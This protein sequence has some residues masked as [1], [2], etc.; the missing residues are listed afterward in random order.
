M[1][2]RQQLGEQAANRI[3]V[4]PPDY[5]PHELKWVIQQMSWFCGTRMHSTIAGLSSG[6]PTIALS[7]SIKT[8]GVFQTCQMGDCVLEL[9]DL[10]TTDVVENL[11]QAWLSRRSL[12]ERLSKSTPKVIQTALNQIE[13][14]VKRVT[15][16]HLSGVQSRAD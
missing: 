11:W 12:K 2:V 8:A 10:S 7:Y 9:R 14:I 5:S 3:A 4:L 1:Q 15:E 13:Q 6:V 16:L